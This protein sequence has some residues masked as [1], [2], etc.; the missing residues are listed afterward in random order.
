MPAQYAQNWVPSRQKRRS[1]ECV[2]VGVR[3]G[4]GV[5]VRTGIDVGG[6]VTRVDDTL[7][8]SDR[9]VDAAPPLSL[10]GGPIT[11]TVVVVVVRA[12]GLGRAGRTAASGVGRSDRRTK[13][14]ERNATENLQSRGRGG[15]LPTI[16]AR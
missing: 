5:A 15:Y 3:I 9:E 10:G 6:V 16:A 7:D 8:G 14:T 4:V 12:A 1:H 11:V 2:D 13:R